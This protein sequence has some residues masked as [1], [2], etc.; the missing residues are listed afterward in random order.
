[1]KLSKITKYALC[2][3]L[4]AMCASCAQNEKSET[5]AKPATSEKA[6]HS[7]LCSHWDIRRH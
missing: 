7:H 4:V 5:N 2:A 3:A 1:M 6:T